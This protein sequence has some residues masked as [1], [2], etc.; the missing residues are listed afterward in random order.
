[1][2]DTSFS[3]LR[4]MRTV[5]QNRSRKTQGALLDAAERLFAKQ[6]LDETSVT[7]IAAEAEVSV[8]ALYHHFRDKCAL[9]HAVIDRIREEMA[10][11]NAAALDPARHEGASIKD[12]LR[13]YICF[14]IEELIGSPVMQLLDSPDL[15]G[16]PDLLTRILEQKAEF[17]AGLA[18]LLRARSGEIGHPDPERAIAFAVDYMAAI[19]KWRSHHVVW[20]RETSGMP[21]EAYVEEALRAVYCYLD[22]KRR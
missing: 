7:E 9:Y 13:G 1:M 5:Q 21:D 12:I 14:V 3:E 4:W 16:M 19:T 8:G 18:A 15:R 17:N 20:P 22:L 10:A 11:T 2:S 6:G